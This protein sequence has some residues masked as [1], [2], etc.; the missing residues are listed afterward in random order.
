MQP[1]KN[2]ADE[3][4]SQDANAKF[5]AMVRDI[6]RQVQWAGD[7]MDEESWKRVLLAAKYGQKIVPN[8]FTGIGMVVVN[9]RRSRGLTKE[10]MA[11]FISE[12]E[13]FGAEHEVDWSEDDES[14]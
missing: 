2:S 13:A 7:F 1:Q 4:R 11:E 5:H 8:P 14:R 12:I 10:E 6:A 3:I 9:T